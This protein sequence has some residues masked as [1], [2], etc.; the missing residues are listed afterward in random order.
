MSN[1][2]ALPPSPAT[3]P[4][5]PRSDLRTPKEAA[6]FLTLSEKTLAKYRCTKEVLL[7]YVKVS[8]KTVRYRQS[9][10]EKFIADRVVA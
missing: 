10:L 9:D 2:Q 6:D 5:L 1:V 8:G 7:P 4:N 3:V